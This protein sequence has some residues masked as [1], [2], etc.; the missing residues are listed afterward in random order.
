ML[1]EGLEQFGIGNWEQISEHIGTKSKEDCA[2]HYDRV[3]INSPEWPLPDMNIIFDI[4]STR[5]TVLGITAQQLVKG[6]VKPPKPPTSA[7]HNHD[8]GGYMPARGE[9]D[10]EYENEA[11][12]NV[13]EMVFEESD[14][15]QDI[16]LLPLIQS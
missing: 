16:R 9:F 3:Y 6:N 12:N 14:T 15:P 4:Q 11:E 5:R 7:P 1:V 13:R 2:A 8:I 10:Q